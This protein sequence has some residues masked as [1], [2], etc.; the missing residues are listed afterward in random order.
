MEDVRAVVLPQQPR[1]N[2]KVKN[3]AQRRNRRV[4]GD[5]GNNL[6][7]AHLV[8]GKP[9][10]QISRPMTRSFHA[11]LLA[12]A[13]AKAE[14][15]G[16]PV[17]PVLE[18]RAAALNRKRGPAKKA[19]VAPKKAIEKPISETLVVISSD[20]E[21]EKDKQVNRCKPIEGP[22]RKEVKTLTSILT[23]RSKAMACGVDIKP[24]EKIVDFDSADVSDE[25]A[26]V[27]YIDD[28]YQFYK[29][30]EDDSRVHDYMESQPEINPKMRSILID[31]LVEVHRKFELMPETFYL[32]VNI[33]DRYL[34][35]KIV[36]RRELQLVGISSMVIASKYEEIWAPQV[37]DFVCLSDYAYTGDQ[38]L[39]MEKAILGK[40]EWYLTVPT[41]YVF[42]SRY[43]KASVSPGEE[44]KNM[45]FF[46]AEL[47]IMHYPTTV[48]YSP[49]LIA[50][51]AVYAARCTLNKAPLW[52]E[53][54]KHHT[55]YSE[56]QLRDCAKLLVGFHLNAAESNLQAV[57]RKFSKP[58]HVAVARIPPAKNFMSSSS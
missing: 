25:L 3:E 32:T 14:K 1:G 19:A 46:L 20:E 12:K 4:L 15:N 33:I 24:K 56:E 49:S 23:A 26:V 45:V 18:D 52:T 48:R 28:L 27:E 57:Y 54:L 16:N 10:V 44:V 13:Q 55:G 5:I 2:D 7:A 22:S 43:I 36:S 17:L 21:E 34:S 41:P 37:I 30:T 6:E 58:E 35:K 42:L 40:L 8:E 9:P 29:L 50:A 47:G 51:A 31:W 11:Q 39:L 38:I 53:T